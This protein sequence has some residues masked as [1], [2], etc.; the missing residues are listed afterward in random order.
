MAWD[1][2]PANSP[3]LRDLPAAIRRALHGPVGSPTLA[4]LAAENGRNTV[5][6]VDDGTRST[7]QA[8]ILPIVR[9]ELNNAGVTD[10]HITVLVALGTHRPMSVAECRQRFGAMVCDRLRVENLSQRMEDFV[11]LGMTAGGIPIQ[12][13]RQYLD[14]DLKI[15]VGNVIPHMYAGWA[16][17]AK[18]V[19]PGVSS[20][21]T[22]AKTHLLASR[23][24]YHILGHVD[25]PVRRE[26]EQ[27][28]VDSGL[29]FIVNVVLNREEKVVFVTAGD[30][31]KAHRRAVAV[32]K[33]IYSVQVPEAVDLVI[34]GAYP[35]DRDLWQGFKPLNNCGMLV[36]DGG[37]LV[38]VI[39]APEGI[40]PDH[41]ELVELGAYSEQRVLEMLDRGEVRDLTAAAT[42]LAFLQTRKR[43]TVSLVSRHIRTLEAARIGVTVD[44]DLQ[45]AVS[46]AIGRLGEKCRIGVVTHGADI[47]GTLNRKGKV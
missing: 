5:I 44:Q 21:L 17:G 15:A 10:D 7:P 22:T 24:V 12:V 16:G 28:A 41:Q 23:N 8:D 34:A 46:A 4:E 20:P 39:P 38:L 29:N 25:N 30:P 1:V 13:S 32:A 40:S 19:Q 37:I 2:A 47:L 43:I 14:A 11:D 42:Y 18:M 27:V 33:D 31:V 35:A 6:L 3:P 9:Q 36:R 45:T 26:M